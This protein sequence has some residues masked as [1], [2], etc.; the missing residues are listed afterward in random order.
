MDVVL[1]NGILLLRVYGVY[2]Q[3]LSQKLYYIYANSLTKSLNP[4]CA[5]RVYIRNIHIETWNWT[6]ALKHAFSQW[7]NKD[8]LEI[9]IITKI[10]SLANKCKWIYQAN[11]KWWDECEAGIH[12]VINPPTTVERIYVNSPIT[13]KLTDRNI[14]KAN[15]SNGKVK[16]YDFGFWIVAYTYPWRIIQ[17]EEPEK[18]I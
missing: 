9:L 10:S 18:C 14:Q 7:V 8:T 5:L 2:L 13:C 1:D 4:H 15:N 11:A 6:T 3:S 16:S 17:E 12:R